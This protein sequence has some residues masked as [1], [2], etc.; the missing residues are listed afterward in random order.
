MR[1]HM[2]VTLTLILL[3]NMF[4]C[5]SV[6]ARCII[7]CNIDFEN[8][9]NPFGGIV[10]YD[11][12]NSIT[13]EGSESNHYAVIKKV[14]G[15]DCHMDYVLQM[16]VDNL[17]AEAD[18]SFGDIGSV[19]TPFYF[20]G[21]AA[22]GKTRADMDAVY[23]DADRKL[24][25][26]YSSGQSPLYTF[27]KNT[28]YRI[29]L[30]VRMTAR[31]ADI[32][33]NG[34]KL[35][36]KQIT[37]SNFNTVK[38]VRNWIRT[39]TANSDFT[40]DNYRIYEADKPS[41]EL[42]DVWES[43]FPDDGKDR[44]QASEI[45][46]IF[47]GRNKA[48]PGLFASEADFNNLKNSSDKANWYRKIKNAADD[49]LAQSPVKY[50]LSDGY[51][52]LPVSR[53]VLKRM[54]LWG[55][56]YQMTSD[57]KYLNRGVREL[58]T[59]CDFEN[60]H[61][62]HFLDTAE[63][64]TAAAIGYDWFYD[65]MTDAQRQKVSDS[66]IE[67]GLKPTRLAYYGRLTT[68]GVAG[69]SMNFVMASN[70]MNI[71]D[72]CGA[73][74]AASAVFEKNKD[75][76]SDV[77]EKAIRSL[78]YSLP[79]FAPDGAWEEGINYCIYS[80]EYIT[81]AVF[82]LNNVFGSDFGISKY[83]GM[84]KAAQWMISLDSYKG[85]NSYHDTWNGM[86]ADT[87]ALSG[88]GKIYSDNAVLKFRRE[89]VNQMKYMPSVFD[90]LWCDKTDTAAE[91]PN[92]LYT[93]K[94]ETVSIRESYFN[95]DGSVNSDGLFFS[96]HGGRNDSYHSHVDAGT[97]VFDIL[98]ERW[99][100]DIPPEDY[101][102]MYGKDN[103]A[104]YRRRAEGHNTVVIDPD[105]SAGQVINASSYV[106]DY[107]FSDNDAYAVYDMSQI[108]S[109]W[110]SAY[111]RGFYVGDN[112][113]SLT[114]RDEITL[115]NTSKI[116]WF[117]HTK[118]DIE[119][120]ENGAIL[121]K[122]GKKLNLEIKSN[123]SFKVSKAEAKPLSTS[124]NPSQTAN[125]GI[126]KAAIELSGS[127]S[128]T[129]E[130]KLSPYEENTSAMMN[131]STSLWRNNLNS[132]T[133]QTIYDFENY[134]SGLP[135]GFKEVNRNGITS[136]EPADNALGH[137]GRSVLV[138]QSATKTP[139]DDQWYQLRAAVKPVNKRYQY[140]HYEQAYDNQFSDRWLRVKFSDN[141]ETS[142][143]LYRFTRANDMSNCFRVNDFDYGIQPVNIGWNSYDVV[144][145]M[146]N[147]TYDVYVNDTLMGK[148]IEMQLKKGGVISRNYKLSGIDELLFGINHQWD[149]AQ[150]AFAATKT[151]MDNI[152]VTPLDEEPVIA[153]EPELYCARDG[154]TCE[155][156]YADSVTY[157]PKNGFAI[158]AKYNSEN[159]LTEVLTDRNGVAAKLFDGEKI[160]LFNWNNLT[161]IKPNGK[162]VEFT[163]KHK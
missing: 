17:V 34:N 123:C 12:G 68:G 74:I 65:G 71:V 29:S 83:E 131:C 115:K 141:I 97:F 105:A 98:D 132:N 45:K 89:T 129:I 77:I 14:N 95:S 55:F 138:K 53:E 86:H 32:Y 18:F 111:K 110:A 4:A 117:M 81:R 120:T 82:A 24:H 127:G 50:E 30:V 144:V 58:D 51:R 56:M 79:G 48:Y 135:S 23:V 44:I 134:T 64:M 43:V 31:V 15:N 54:Q 92:E 6:Q 147:K 145:D 155:L 154:I 99:A 2:A 49:L 103:N 162:A 26:S 149:T 42:P 160:K 40:M 121:T 137:A 124:P 102:L 113:R 94:A 106:T 128:V 60:W 85:V 104:Y 33:V 16:S 13:V 78:A 126:Y 157:N 10:R 46:R 118:A 8:S 27:E 116:Y 37:D 69:P 101:N 25:L 84:N 62:E 158:I 151:Y 57:V 5:I 88:L 96:T 3:I 150:N 109:T 108:Y 153:D 41:T 75:L 35:A 9:A 143:P 112:R 70:N 11:K 93:G 1:K 159:N 130:V 67:K 148:E 114:V 63:M 146:Q 21:S 19:I 136:V 38:S 22:D 20:I 91:P 107:M 39:G 119:P 76:C 28:T 59:I 80:T 87:F 90:L 163:V 52:L 142:I 122:N 140:I 139:G 61:P 133:D 73:I 152:R 47:S 7:F 100:M 156:T 125:D 72:N 66:V 36:E 161:D